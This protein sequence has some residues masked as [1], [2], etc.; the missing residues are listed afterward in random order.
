MAVPSLTK[1]SKKMGIQNLIGKR[2]SKNFKFM[3]EDVKISKLSV[4]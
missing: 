3:G 1:E 4:S 2:M